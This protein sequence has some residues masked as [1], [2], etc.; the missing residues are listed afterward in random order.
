VDHAARA[1][2]AT[3]AIVLV[4]WVA[5]ITVAVAWGEQVVRAG[6][7]LRLGAPPLAGEYDWRIGVD[8]LPAAAAGVALVAAGPTAARRARWRSLLLYA[9]LASLAWAVTLALVDGWGGLTDPL[10]PK[11]YLRTVPRVG[12]PFT[13]LATFSD[14]LPEYNIHTQGHPPGMVLIL[15]GLDRIGLGGTGWN[16]VLVF[17]GGA[18]T[19]PAALVATREVAGEAS[20]RAAAPFLTLLPAAIWW[21]SGDAL[22]AGMST[23]AATLVILATGRSGRAADTRAALG[24]VLFGVVA[25]LSYGLVLL[26][27]VPLVVAAARR[28]AR[29]IA[30]ALVGASLVFLA[31]AATGFWWPDGLAATHERYYAGV[32]SRRPYEYFVFGNLA[33]FAL[34]LGPAVAVG[35]AWLR[36]RRLW[37]LVGAGLAAVALAD[38]S[39]MSKAEVER[40]WLPFVPWV[41]LAAASLGRP[42][43]PGSAPRGWLGLQAASGYLLQVAVRSPW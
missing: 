42:G 34:A 41:V 40:I 10:V 33:A 22:F 43:A 36:D 2:A 9:A 1:R 23:V 30:V 17:T 19:A 29:P 28:R 24:G 8:A 6:S 4:G 11:Q 31:F 25:F 16:A 37:L 7:W 39:G 3:A 14:R 12:D 26:A 27:C 5:A 13:F 32:A 20:A 21:T 35:L 38:V 18:L 15:W